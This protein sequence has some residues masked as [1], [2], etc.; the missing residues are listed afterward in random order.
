METH[1]LLLLPRLKGDYR[2]EEKQ[3]QKIATLGSTGRAEFQDL[4]DIKK[5]QP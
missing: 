2:V 1:H 4:D 3:Q 5:Q